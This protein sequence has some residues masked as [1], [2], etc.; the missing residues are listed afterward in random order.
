MG[1]ESVRHLP[2]RHAVP[3]LAATLALGACGSSGVTTPKTVAESA[4]QPATPPAGWRTMLN[5]LHGFSIAVPPGW[6]VEESGDAVLI[7][8]PDHLVA[9][10]LSV[11]RTP[12]AF[13][14]PPAAFARQAI[15]ALPGYDNPLRPGPL[16]AISGTPLRAIETSSS[17]VASAGSVR[18]DIELAVLRRDHLVNYTAVI[19]AN[20]GS[21][22][23][24]E[25]ALASRMLTTIR[26]LPIG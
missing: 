11:D 21:A 12:Q 15:Q 6:S 26:N 19:A 5:H 10:S 24:A 22:P 7:R 8:S 14:S 9:V 1:P 2:I 16:R 23:A 20:A 25:R 18:Q 4:Q 3:A 13:S 17:G